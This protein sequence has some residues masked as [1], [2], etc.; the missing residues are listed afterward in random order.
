MRMAIPRDQR[1]VISHF[2]IPTPLIQSADLG[3]N[4]VIEP[5]SFAGQAQGASHQAGKNRLQTPAQLF[6]CADVT[7]LSLS[8]QFVES[9]V[10]VPHERFL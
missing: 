4:K 10:T 3:L 9:K 8:L 2:F 5:G 1:P 7:T 6:V